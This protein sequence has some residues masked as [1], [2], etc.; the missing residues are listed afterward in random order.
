MVNEFDFLGVRGLGGAATSKG[1]DAIADALREL[2]IQGDVIN[3]EFATTAG[4]ALRQNSDRKH[5][6]FGYSMG[7]ADAIDI[8][9]ALVAA[10]KEVPFLFTMDPAAQRSQVD[11]V[12]LHIN[13]W[14]EHAMFGLKPFFR[15]A[16][17]STAK[18]VLKNIKAKDVASHGDLDDT[19]WVQEVFFEQVR[20]LI[21]VTHEVAS[22]DAH[23]SIS[24]RVVRE[25]TARQ[26]KP[27]ANANYDSLI[28]TLD[29]P[30]SR[31]MDPDR[32]T[33]AQR[34]WQEAFFGVLRREF[35]GLTTDSVQGLKSIIFCHRKFWSDS[36]LPYLAWFL[37]NIRR[38]VGPNMRPIKETQRA[39]EKHV[40]D[41][42][43]VA[44]LNNWWASGDAQRAQVRTQYWLEN[45][46]FP[47]GRG[48]IQT[49]WHNNYVETRRVVLDITGFDIPFDEDYNLMLDPLASA[50]GGFAMA[51][52]GKFTGSSLVEH[53]NGD[54]TFDYFNA[55]RVVNG[56]T[57]NFKLIAGYCRSFERALLAAEDAVPGWLAGEY[58]GMDVE[59]TP[60]AQPI[61]ELDQVVVAPEINI[62]LGN[63][64]APQLVA[65]I[66]AA[67]A[68][69]A[70]HSELEFSPPHKIIHQPD[71]QR[72]RGATQLGDQDTTGV[73]PMQNIDGLKTYIVA[74]AMALI[75]LSEGVLGIDIPGAEMQSNWIEYILG[76]AG[77]GTGRHAIAKLIKA[78]I[79]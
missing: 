76:A 36:P 5:I 69:L 44:R 33:D 2:G 71:F 15:V 22:M 34:L 64:T 62:N 78:V 48:L 4:V 41:A 40:S 54:G 59:I 53:L 25:Q 21:E 68:Q 35:G 42:T 13:V 55:R 73:N 3:Q 1:I 19:P 9:Q 51:L 30:W 18:G 49:T 67:S 10:G 11:G 66:H 28:D 58:E 60:S 74:F 12:G 29:V 39:G 56:D 32:E 17:A 31:F 38:E 63:A 23:Q 45:S 50:I 61:I 79:N 43:V 47:F 70:Q 75:A 6:I 14:Q 57:K 20:G 7:A 65:F 27:V 16:H 8:A 77:L 46:G 37:G 72:K 52:R 26:L 24:N